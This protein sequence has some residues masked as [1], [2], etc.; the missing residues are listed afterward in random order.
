MQNHLQITYYLVMLFLILGIVKLVE[1]VKENQLEPYL[2]SVGVLVLAGL[3]GASTNITRILTTY[4]YG[5]ESMRGKSEL[6]NDLDNKTSGLDKDYA[7]AWS[8]G[9]SRIVYAFDS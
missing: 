1:A 5:E 3:L 9:K 2:K 8:Y 4:E 7:T 6:T